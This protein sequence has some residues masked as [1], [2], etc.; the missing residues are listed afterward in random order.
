MMS[1]LC[2]TTAGSSVNRAGNE[3]A[4]QVNDKGQENGSAKGN[5]QPDADALFD[6]GVLA[7]AVILADKGGD[8]NAEGVHHHPEQ[9]VDLA[10]DRPA[11]HDVGAERVDA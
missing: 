2:R 4:E 11:C 3:P 5:G 1:R 9:A 10:V 7:R 8:G 6:A